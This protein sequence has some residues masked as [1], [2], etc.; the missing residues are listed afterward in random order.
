MAGIRKRYFA[1]LLCLS[2]V[3]TTPFC[4]WGFSRNVSETSILSSKTTITVL[5][6]NKLIVRREDSIVVADESGKELGSDAI[7][8]T[9]FIK[10]RKLDA[11]IYDLSGRL[12]RKLQKKDIRESSLSLT[13]VFNEHKTKFYSSFTVPGLPYRL[14]R[15]R[16]YEI[17]SAFFWPDW[18][19]QTTVDV[20]HARLE[21]IL[22]HQVE[23]EYRNIGDLAQPEISAGPDGSK[24]YVWAIDD[25][26]AFEDEYRS[27]PE[28]AFQMG[29]KF[30][31][32]KF[33]L[34]GFEGTSK[35][36]RAFGSWYYALIKDRLSLT[37]EN[38]ATIPLLHAVSRNERIRQIYRFLQAQT[39]YVQIYLNEGGW[40]P[41]D[42]NR[43]KKMKY[44]DCKDLSIFMIAML[45]QAGIEA[46]PALVLTRDRGWVDPGFPANNFNHCIAVVPFEND[47]L[48]LE[49][50]S[51]VTAFD[52][53]PASI[54]GVNVLLI[55]PD[56]GQLLRT[57]VSTAEKN[58]SKLVA[59]AQLFR[60]RHLR[61]EGTLMFTGNS[62]ISMRASLS[63]VDQKEQKEWLVRR[64]SRK[65]GDARCTLLTID[66][67][68][69]PDS[70]L[71]I[72]FDVD[73]Q[74]FARKAGNRLII[75][76]RLFH[77][78]TFDG[79]DPSCRTMPLLNLTRF[80]EEDSIVFVLPESFRVRG[81]TKSDTVRSEFGEYRFDMLPQ[82]GGLLW[83]SSFTSRART[84]PLVDYP[85]YYDFM[86][87]VGKQASPKVV[88][89]KG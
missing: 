9:D 56:G 23:F 54:E 69:D 12:L 2:G 46:H 32:R 42:V 64:F 60:D 36:W 1:V 40:R 74:Y 14:T 37:A 50:T 80:V 65:A 6:E 76:P 85:D 55:K 18:N 38:A 72:R 10:F 47:T 21:L 86:S 88:L 84:V 11:R 82:K 34:A 29:V 89:Q 81:S 7:R 8:Q 87:S 19:P 13:S 57:P 66:N 59:R 39:R 45:A 63:A 83:R 53:P 43:I 77:R 79:E 30:M 78:W 33:K 17:K 44:G 5:G 35:D 15:V 25:V 75:E 16:E 41:H 3:L 58:R 24:R 71:T 51:D 48:W 22:K 27:A 20:E 61:V 4:S 70:L 28:A 49:C 26:P 67:L 52:D 68:D 31:P 62:A 73:L